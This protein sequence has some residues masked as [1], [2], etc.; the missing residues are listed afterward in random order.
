MEERVGGGGMKEVEGVEV[1]TTAKAVGPSCK[2][3][4]GGGGED[5]EEESLLLLLGN[6]KMTTSTRSEEGASS[7]L[8][9]RT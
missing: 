6:E 8:G 1:R 5:G 3:S 2:S 7:D 9:I 4:E